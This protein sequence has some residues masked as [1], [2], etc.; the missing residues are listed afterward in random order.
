MVV[1][2]VVD[3]MQD[4]ILATSVG[5]PFPPLLTPDFRSSSDRELIGA[6]AVVDGMR[7]VS[8]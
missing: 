4:G 3:R 7:G 8:A 6:V 5:F 2:A 1:L